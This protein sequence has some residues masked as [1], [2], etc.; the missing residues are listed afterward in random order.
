MEYVSS[1]IMISISVLNKYYAFT[2]K[3]SNKVINIEKRVNFSHLLKF[4]QC[5]KYYA[6]DCVYHERI[7]I[8]L[9]EKGVPTHSMVV[10]WRM[11][12]RKWQ[13]KQSLK[14][15]PENSTS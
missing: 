13:S 15:W 11:Q 9:K 6:F 10:L 5:K 4:E 12:I 1:N 2:Q 3:S 14:R 8:I 7:W